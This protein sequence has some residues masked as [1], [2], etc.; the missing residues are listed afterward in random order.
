MELNLE[1][2]PKELQDSF[3]ESYDKYKNNP[4]FVSRDGQ[5]Q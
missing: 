4:V 2:L 3:Q 1:D 5:S